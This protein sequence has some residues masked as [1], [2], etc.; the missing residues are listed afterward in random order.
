LKKG[1]QP[2]SD[3][4]GK[5]PVPGR[6]AEVNISEAA[7]VRR[8]LPDIVSRIYSPGEILGV[9]RLAGGAA[10]GGRGRRILPGG[11][12]RQEFGS[13]PMIID[14]DDKSIYPITPWNLVKL[15]AFHL[16]IAR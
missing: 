5:R 3:I 15:D 9:R 13:V 6:L 8:H 11:N 14:N 12:D 7:A 2:R 1:G 16:V 4:D 10:A